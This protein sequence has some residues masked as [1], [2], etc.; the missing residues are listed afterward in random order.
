MKKVR[1]LQA[2]YEHFTG[3]YG[4]NSFTNGVSDEPLLPIHAH[5]I[6]AAIAAEYEDGTPIN[7]ALNYSLAVDMKPADAEQVAQERAA[8]AAEHEKKV[9]RAAVTYTRE[10]LEEIADKRG[11]K[12]LREIGDD[13][14]VKANSVADLIA[15]ILKAQ[16]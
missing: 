15:G 11:I 5:F 4:P 6:G 14:G 12:G 1:L 8:I 2:G 13:L 3:Q 10:Q 7:P 9:A 16:E